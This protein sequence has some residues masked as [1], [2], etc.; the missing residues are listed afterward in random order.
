MA[1]VSGYRWDQ[2]N[3]LL[4]PMPLLGWWIGGGG[5][6]GGGGVGGGGGEEE[7]RNFKGYFHVIWLFSFSLSLLRLYY[8]W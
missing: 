3:C 5:G 2:I 4:S 8:M 1:Y 6:G 7:E